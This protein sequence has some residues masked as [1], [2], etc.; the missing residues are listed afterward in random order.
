MSVDR[1]WKGEGG[2]KN[3]YLNH[4]EVQMNN[5]FPNCGLKALPHI[6]SKVK[7]FKDKYVV[8]SEMVNKTSGFQWDD[9]T[10]MIQCE[11]QAF[12]DFV[13]NHP[14]AGGL[15]RTPFPYLEKLDNVFGVDRAN[16]IAS[17]LPEDSINNLEEIVNLANDN[18]DDDGLPQP[19]AAKKIKKEKT[20]KSTEKKK[21]PQ[22]LDLTSNQMAT[23]FT[24]FMKGMSSH[25]ETIANAMSSTQNREIEVVE[26]KKRLL[27][28]IASLPGMT[29]AEAIRAACLFTSN[30]SQMDV[31]FSSPDDDWKKEVVFDLIHHLATLSS[32]ID[33]A[34]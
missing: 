25:L 31:F 9:K 11:K 3:G 34:E 21:S 7:W 8:V 16:G 22:I 2:F 4:L 26:Q 24:G 29:K 27:S 15:W 12:D 1:Q 28:E 32:D 5:K 17:E 14:K 18:S 13:K 6:D 20:P 33:I 19:P 23:E 10:K 30:P